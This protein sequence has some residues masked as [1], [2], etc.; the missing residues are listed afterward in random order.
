MRL[1]FY[2][3]N[4]TNCMDLFVYS[5]ESGVFDK[6]HNEYFVFGGL[7]FCSYKD[8]DEAI[9][10][11]KTAERCAMLKDGI[12]FDCEAKACVLSNESKGKLFRSLN[13]FHKFGVV[14]QQHFVLN[15]IFQNKKSKQRYLD[16]V[17]KIGIKRKFQSM[18]KDGLIKPDEVRRI[19]FYVDEHST[20]T[21]GRYE[22]RES[23][24]QE[25]KL[26]TYNWKWNK[27]YPPIFTE[28]NSIELSFCDSKTRPLIRAA[29]IVA[30]KI[31]HCAVSEEMLYLQN[32]E[33]L[34]TTYLPL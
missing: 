13:R 12:P 20:A 30:N 8:V 3:Y 5:D 29:D 2:N 1:F 34:H 33:N 19:R 18:I 24:E 27:F 21:D 23:L 31:Y 25:F 7:V 10:L 22:L 32:K 26:G 28:I 9:A 14:V 15:N 11:Y 6:V 17:F 16:Y 4:K